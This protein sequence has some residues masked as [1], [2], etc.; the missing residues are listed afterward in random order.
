MFR[1]RGIETAGSQR[2]QKVE[3]SE[4]DKVT[5]EGFGEEVQVQL[6]LQ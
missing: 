2:A 3:L 6:Q 5:L 1:G 4:T